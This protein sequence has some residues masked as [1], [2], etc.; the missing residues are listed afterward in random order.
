M[1]Y[2]VLEC[3]KCLAIGHKRESCTN[4]VRCSKC[5]NYGHIQNECLNSKRAMWILKKVR[6]TVNADTNLD[7]DVNS[8]VIPYSASN[9]MLPDNH[10]LT[11]SPPPYLAA[12]VHATP[13]ANFEYILLRLNSGFPHFIFLFYI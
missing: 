6:P 9:H 8:S 5:F 3:G 12:L 1:I 2:R 10:V 11:P 13:M 4:E 7:M